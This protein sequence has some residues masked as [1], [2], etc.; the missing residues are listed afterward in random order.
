MGEN[1]EVPEKMDCG[2]FSTS[3]SKL[4]DKLEINSEN[5][6]D[7]CVKVE[8]NEP[9]TPS[10]YEALFEG[11]SWIDQI[12]LEEQLVEAR[13]PGRAIEIH[14]KLSSPARKREPHEAFKHHQE[15]Q[16][17][18]RVRRQMFQDEKAQRLVALNTRIEEVIAHR[19]FLLSKRREMIMKKMAKAEA[20]RQE[21][22]DGIRKK[23][24]EEE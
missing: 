22:I 21:H 12:E 5:C 13:M 18:A 7:M 1:N 11:L 6:G 3:S 24:G 8:S 15:K 16:N 20:K 4:N 2:N 23:A 10:K 17:K 19:E 14:E 9:C